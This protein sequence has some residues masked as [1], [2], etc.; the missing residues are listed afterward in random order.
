MKKS[1]YL[2]QRLKSNLSEKILNKAKRD[3]VKNFQKTLIFR[4]FYY[5]FFP[6]L[7]HC[8]YYKWR[9]DGCASF[10]IWKFVK[11]KKILKHQAIQSFETAVLKSKIKRK[12]VIFASTSYWKLFTEFKKVIWQQLFFLTWNFDWTYIQE[13]KSVPNKS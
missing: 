7:E 5:T 8:A 4:H 2:Q 9:W 3:Q 11:E 12:I 10:Q 13:E 1:Y 6:F